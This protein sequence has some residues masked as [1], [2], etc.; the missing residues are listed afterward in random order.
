MN[1]EDEAI[2]IKEEIESASREYGISHNQ[3]K[4]A[5]NISSDEL[6]KLRNLAF[7]IMQGE[8]DIDEVGKY[9]KQ[10]SEELNEMVKELI[11]SSN[12]STMK[13]LEAANPYFD[14]FPSKIIKDNILKGDDE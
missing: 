3:S 9:G 11:S 13:E 6:H 10:Y 12:S 7:R 4:M 2:K 1:K 14:V 5:K 8:I